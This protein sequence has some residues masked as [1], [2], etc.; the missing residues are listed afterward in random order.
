ML[1]WDI[2]KP[3]AHIW[4]AYT[5][6]I[7]SEETTLSGNLTSKFRLRSELVSHSHESLLSFSPQ[8]LFKV[9][10]DVNLDSNLYR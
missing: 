1:E 9:N 6:P 10:S 4:E 5:L 2:V 3:A 7:Q 8:I